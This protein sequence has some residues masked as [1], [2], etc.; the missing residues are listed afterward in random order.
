MELNLKNK[1][2]NFYI[3]CYASDHPCEK[4]RHHAINIKCETHRCQL[5]KCLEKHQLCDGK[6]DCHDASDEHEEVCS[7]IP[8]DL[9]HCTSS[10]YRCNNG[11]C[12]EKS[13]FCNHMNDCGDESDE[14][15]ECTCF[16]YLK[17]T[18]SNK[19]CDGIRHCWDKTDENPVYCGTKC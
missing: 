17:A 12:I 16:N 5:G 7:K 4:C 15:S 3:L 8:E 14:P 18:D 13:K 2:R 1:I 19:I 10:Q 6:K 11:K 9:K